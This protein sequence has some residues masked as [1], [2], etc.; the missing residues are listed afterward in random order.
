MGTAKAPSNL[1]LSDLGRSKSRALVSSLI[2]RNRGEL[3]HILLLNFN[4]KPHME[5]PM[6]P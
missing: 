6:T 2:D 4:R 5:N 1:K 3:Y